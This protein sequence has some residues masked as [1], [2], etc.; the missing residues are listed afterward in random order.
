MIPEEHPSKI[1]GGSDSSLEFVVFEPFPQEEEKN[2]LPLTEI[3]PVKI[4]QKNQV[5]ALLSQSVQQDETSQEEK[6]DEML[7]KQ[8]SPDKLEVG[9]EKLISAHPVEQV[10][11]SKDAEEKEIQ[12]FSA[13]KH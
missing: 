3:P 5:F 7:L 6:L 13:S 11:P 8:L 1:K 2:Q 12:R 10:F 9:T 4:E